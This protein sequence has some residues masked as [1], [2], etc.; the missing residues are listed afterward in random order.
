VG[1]LLASAPRA[2]A[3]VKPGSDTTTEV[4]VSDPHSVLVW[5]FRT[6][7]YDIAFSVTYKP[8]VR[9]A[10]GQP[11]SGLVF[12]SNTPS[13]R[14]LDGETLPSDA[15]N[16]VVVKSYAR[17]NSHARTIQGSF[18]PA[19]VG[20]GAGTAVLR[21]DNSYSTFRSKSLVY[22]T[23]VVSETEAAAAATTERTHRT[24]LNQVRI[25]GLD[26]GLGCVCSLVIC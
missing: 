10:G 8:A 21:W 16:D 12:R 3:D 23:R 17:V 22:K 11:R 20:V 19:S 4:V 14:R 25:P 18:C 13:R 5:E 7:D 24:K 2:S 26:G 1:V 15:S 9:S 6:Q